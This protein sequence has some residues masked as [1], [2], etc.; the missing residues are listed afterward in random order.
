MPP[1]RIRT[2]IHT[3]T[4]D[5]AL[6]HR[7]CLQTLT[8]EYCKRCE[9]HCR[10]NHYR[11]S[12]NAAHIFPKGGTNNIPIPKTA[13]TPTFFF[14][15]IWSCH[16]VHS[17]SANISKSETTLAGPVIVRSIYWLMQDPGTEGFQIFSRGVHVNIKTIVIGR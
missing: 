9:Q 4:S 16:M 8:V 15:S 10:R 11:W 3:P 12:L 1:S 7:S 14:I 2:A 5:S 17:G 13:D 6:Q